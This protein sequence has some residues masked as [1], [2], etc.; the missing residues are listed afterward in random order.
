M[1]DG[2]QGGIMIEYDQINDLM[3]LDVSLYCD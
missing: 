3:L 2:N 1:P